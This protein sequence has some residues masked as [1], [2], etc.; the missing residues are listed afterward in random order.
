MHLI[1]YIHSA[2]TRYHSLSYSAIPCSFLGLDQKGWL[3]YRCPFRSGIYALTQKARAERTP[4]GDV[5][6]IRVRKLKPE[7]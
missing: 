5:T 2:P 6:D 4:P 7:I 1:G 3:P